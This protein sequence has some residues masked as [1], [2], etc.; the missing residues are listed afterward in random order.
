MGRIAVLFSLRTTDFDKVYL[1]TIKSDII[2]FP[3][4]KGHNFDQLF[5]NYLPTKVKEERRNLYGSVIF[6]LPEEPITCR[7][8]F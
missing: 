4:I 7:P 2:Q 5:R 3:V 8:S 1:F 6:K